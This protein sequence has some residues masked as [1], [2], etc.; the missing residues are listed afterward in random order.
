MVAQRGGAQV[1]GLLRWF[2]SRVHKGIHLIENNV[3]WDP[4]YEAINVQA[5]YAPWNKD[6][7][8]LQT[9]QAVK[10][11][12][13]VDKYR[14][15][16]LWSLVEQSKKL[17]G[18]LIEIGVW[19]G[20]TG[21]LIA[22]KARL[23]GI[24][25]PVY[26]CDTFKGVVKAS[27]KDPLYKGGEHA[28]TSRQIVEE[29]VTT[30]GLD[31]VH[32]LEGVFPDQTAQ[33]IQEKRFRLCHIDVDVYDSARDIVEWLWNRMVAGGI[34]IYDDYGFEGCSGIT[35]YVEEQ[36]SKAD[37]LVIHNLN[38]HALIVKIK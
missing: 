26:L 35:R 19:R 24:K 16:E 20:S 32:I 1:R 22:K 38:G 30:L 3:R 5:N 6:K 21:A 15:F 17:D 31:N 13:F 9:Y 37:R 14:C 18:A 27:E 34:V 29:L 33:W 25:D 4:N 11:N 2:G 8:F 28:D 36:T 12:T 10:A 23:C 7:I